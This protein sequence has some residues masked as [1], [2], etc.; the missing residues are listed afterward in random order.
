LGR[1]DDEGFTEECEQAV[2]DSETLGAAFG[3][4]EQPTPG[5]DQVIEEV[6][7]SELSANEE[8]V[9]ECVQEIRSLTCED[10]QGV[11][12][13]NEFRNVEQIIPDP[14]CSG[15]FSGP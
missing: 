2:G 12:V 8:A 10:L 15:V 13:D 7:N 3:I 5:F 14:P 11:E 1:T 4:E 9:E 6:E